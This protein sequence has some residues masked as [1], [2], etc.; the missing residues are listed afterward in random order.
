MTTQPDYE[1]GTIPE[2]TLATRLR[3]A[4]EHA[5]LEQ[6]QLAELM[7][8]ARNTVSRSENGAGT[9][10]TIVLKAWAL[11]TGVPLEWIETGAVKRGN[12]SPDGGGAA[13]SEP[14][15]YMDEG[16]DEPENVITVD[17]WPVAPADDLERAA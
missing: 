9:P 8:I 15:D 14:L 7:G 4:R 17:F 1:A 16:S 11:A 10:R 12:P 13:K 3:L 6:G 5:G 2:I